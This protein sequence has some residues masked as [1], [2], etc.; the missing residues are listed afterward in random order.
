MLGCGMRQH[1]LVTQIAPPIQRKF[2]DQLA[3]DARHLAIAGKLDQRV[4]K[5]Q[6]Q[7]VIGIRIARAHRSVHFFD[8][9]AHGFYLLGSD[10]FG[11]SPADQLVH[12]RAKIK[13]LQSLF[14]RNLAHE[15]AA[16]LLLPHQAGFLEHPKRFADR[17][18][19]NSQALRQPASVVWPPR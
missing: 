14:E 13:N 9:G 15:Y 5:L 16:V 17:S 11:E 4:V 8:D 2:L 6:V 3:V 1:R 7:E 19:G 10:R 12:R 18:P